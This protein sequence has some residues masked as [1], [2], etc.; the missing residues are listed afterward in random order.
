MKQVFTKAGGKAQ[1]ERLCSE[2]DSLALQAIETVK[3]VIGKVKQ[4]MIE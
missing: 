3:N 4:R 1:L 2:M